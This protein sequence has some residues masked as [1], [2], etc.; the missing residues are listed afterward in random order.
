MKK[1]I[2]A[3]TL[4]GLAV[5]WFLQP[6]LAGTVEDEIRELKG[7]LKQLEKRLEE[8]NAA[9]EEQKEQI[10]EV[11][12]S[13]GII[14]TVAERIEFHGLVEVGSFWRER[15][16]RHRW[17]N[18]L[19]DSDIQLT[20]VELGIEGSVFDWL[21]FNLLPLY[22]E[23][24]DDSNIFIDEASV[25]LGGTENIP[26]Y[27][28]GG[29]LYVPYGRLYTRF[30]D[31]PLT[32]M[33]VT[34]IFGET[35]ESGAIFGVSKYGLTFDSYIFHAKVDASDFGE[36]MDNYGF[37]LSYAFS[38]GLGSFELGGSYIDN[39]AAADA[40]EL[41]GPLQHEV[42]G[43]AA[44]LSA[45]VGNAFLTAEFMIATRRLQLVDLAS[46]Y[47]DKG[48]K[49]SVWN[50]EAGYNFENLFP[51]PLELTF[52]YAGSKDAQAIGDL[53][54]NRWGVCANIGVFDY[55]TYS[56][57]YVYDRFGYDFDYGPREGIPEFREEG[58]LLV[59]QLSVEF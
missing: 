51:K 18:S 33:P 26:F 32:N 5:L 40:W 38:N 2:L 31:D 8:Q 17:P 56:L 7:R 54:K 20:T 1:G 37:D 12:E 49:P 27:L 9:V 58:H 24:T 3:L 57:A 25:T 23:E 30:P 16:N 21:S 53:P 15:K 19:S 44:Y 50:F 39:V 28:T 6:A 13:R 4:F 10:A 41:T 14:D 59:T 45:E 52:K 22:E 42:G 55:T 36:H 46:E 29:K 48:A 47:A 11:K 43:G 34:L 35:R